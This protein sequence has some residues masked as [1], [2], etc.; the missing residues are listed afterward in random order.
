MDKPEKCE[1]CNVYPA[2]IKT[3]FGWLCP[4]CK[5]FF[6]IPDH[7]EVVEDDGKRKYK[8]GDK[9]RIVWALYPVPSYHDTIEAVR[10]DGTYVLRFDNGHL[11]ASHWKDY[12]LIPL[13]GGSA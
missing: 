6:N 8:V 12:E 5:G 3:N 13:E 1:S 7:S 10:A 9:V 2:S 4:E 11:S